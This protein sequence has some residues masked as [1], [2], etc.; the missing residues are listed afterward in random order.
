MRCK[1]KTTA[2]NPER[3][4]ALPHRLVEGLLLGTTLTL[5]AVAVQGCHP[6]YEYR[7]SNYGYAVRLPAA[8][9]IET[10]EPPF[11]NH[12]FLVPLAPTTELWVD[13]FFTDALTLDAAVM[14]EREIRGDRCREITRRPS[15]LGSLSAVE[16]VFQCTG[17]PPRAQSTIVTEVM[18][19]RDRD[20][21]IEYTVK[22]QHPVVDDAT[23]AESERVFRRL[24]D[25]FYLIDRR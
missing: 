22:S 24:I 2:R 14:E 18:A 5:A 19:L 13:A 11:P 16:S 1:V 12:G 25:G 4:N 7:N 8:L 10:T 23:W 20:G 3:G 9:K 6:S 17:E 15:R 21:S